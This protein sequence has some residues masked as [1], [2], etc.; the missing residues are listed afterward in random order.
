MAAAI[1]NQ[2]AELLFSKEARQ[3]RCRWKNSS[4]FTEFSSVRWFTKEPAG[5]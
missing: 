3:S 2:F 4:G 5:V 1:F